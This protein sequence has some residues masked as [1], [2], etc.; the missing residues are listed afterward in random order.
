MLSIHLHVVSAVIPPYLQFYSNRD[1]EKPSVKYSGAMYDKNL[2]ERL[3]LG[4]MGKYLVLSSRKFFPA[5][6]FPFSDL[7]Y[8]KVYNL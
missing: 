1:H 2:S 3:R 8:Q 5:L 7:P 6:R 4:W